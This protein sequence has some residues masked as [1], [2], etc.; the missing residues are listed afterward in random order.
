M[1]R[2]RTGGAWRGSLRG[3]LWASPWFV[4]LACLTVGPLLFSL[5]ISLTDW[6]GISDLGPLLRPGRAA[7]AGGRGPADQ[8]PRWVGLANYRDAFVPAED[9]TFPEALWKDEFYRSLLNT[10]IYA[11]SSV[12]LTLAA[13]LGLALLLN[14]KLRGIAVFRTIFFM[15]AMVSGIA[16]MVMWRWVYNAEYGLLNTG[17]RRLYAAWNGL[18]ARAGGWGLDLGRLDMS[19][20]PGWIE[21]VRWALPS[22]I[23][24][25]VW[26]AGSAMMIFLAGLQN[27]PEH[28]YEAA[29]MDGAGR[30][31]KFVHITLP[32]LSPTIFFNLVMGIIGSFQVFAQAYL[33]PSSPGGPGNATLVY[34]LHLY[35]KA[36]GE[37][38]MGYAC[39][40]GWILFGVILGVTL[41]LVLTSRRWVYYEGESA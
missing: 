28:L 39:A 41:G 29:S 24:M 27:V 33:L 12:V 31:R 2:A 8:G 40:L 36:F 6:N 3:Y 7:A 18:A 25:S 20:V 23:F 1:N 37:N 19:A 10:A 30:W 5:A 17:L 38:E 4:G 26:G 34:V 11:V 35:L 16:T 32:Q 13:A 9:L 21:S 14:Q 22:L 15:P